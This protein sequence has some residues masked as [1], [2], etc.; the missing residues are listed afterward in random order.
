MPDAYG[1]IKDRFGPDCAFGSPASGVTTYK[2]G[3]PLEVL[4]KP[5]SRSGLAWLRGFCSEN[6]VPF[7]VLGA[8]SNI[9]VSDRGLAGVAALTV[10]MDKTEISGDLLTAEAGALW[11]N[12]VRAA[13]SA[14]L[15]GLEKTSGI[16]GTA[17]GAVFMNAG[18]F[19]QEAFDRLES[20]EVMAP[21]GAVKTVKK[22]EVKYG[23]RKVS[24]LEGLVILKAAF[25]L[26]A[27]DKNAL[28]AERARVLARRAENQPL[29]FPSAGSVF[30][31]PAEDFASRLIDTAGLKG[32]AI[33][34]ARV[35]EKHAGFIINAGGASASDIYALIKKVRVEVKVRLGVELELEQILLGDFED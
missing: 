17:G 19:G 14:G 3:G 30:K 4:V 13:V 16:P 8:G 7:L 23:Y 24:G 22:S 5:S 20:F 25:R 28:E 27:G 6:K 32:L 11:D 1:L 26:K 12:V 31:R 33:G 29:D 15:A 34:G 35:S 18:A 2:A 21:S 9:L 10:K